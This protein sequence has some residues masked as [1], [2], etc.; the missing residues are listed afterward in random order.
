MNLCV[1]RIDVGLVGRYTSGPYQPKLA[2][3]GPPEAAH[4]AADALLFFSHDA[5]DVEDTT[6]ER[7]AISVGNAIPVE[8]LYLKPED[9]RGLL[10]DKATRDETC[11]AVRA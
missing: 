6:I 8:W 4:A 3:H 10:R 7:H 9:I 11:N 1:E 5:A 2:H